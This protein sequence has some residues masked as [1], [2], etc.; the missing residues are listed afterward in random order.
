LHSPSGDWGWFFDK[1]MVKEMGFPNA[2]FIMDRFH[3]FDSGLKK[4]FGNIGYDLLQSYLHGLVNPS[5][6]EEFDSILE[7]AH[8]LLRQ[9]PMQNGVFGMDLTTFASRR[10]CYALYCLE[11]IPGNRHQKG[12]T[13][14]ESNHLSVLAYLNGGL[15]SI[16]SD[17]EHPMLLI[18][19]FL[20][21]QHGHVINTNDWL[22]TMKQQMIIVRAKLELLPSSYI[23]EICEEVLKTSTNDEDAIFLFQEYLQ[24]ISARAK[25]FSYEIICDNNDGLSKQIL[26]ILWMTATM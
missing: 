25:G 7:S 22:F 12:N 24:L 1:N 26:G 4:K 3:L 10:Q 11:E 16:N 2:R 20:K 9:Q 15:R 8:N 18:Q 6:K 23:I 14:S 17:Q 13:A 19:D 5:S 21:R